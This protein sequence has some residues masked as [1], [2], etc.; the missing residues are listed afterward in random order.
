MPRFW[1]W[2][3]YYKYLFLI[4]ATTISESPDAEWTKSRNLVSPCKQHACQDIKVRLF[5]EL[6]FLSCTACCISSGTCTPCQLYLLCHGVFPPFFTKIKILIKYLYLLTVIHTDTR[7]VSNK[8]HFSS[9]VHERQAPNLPFQLLAKISRTG[10]KHISTWGNGINLSALKAVVNSLTLYK[11]VR[12]WQFR[13]IIKFVD[14]LPFNTSQ[15]IPLFYNRL[16]HIICQIYLCLQA[17][18]F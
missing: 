4:K 6:P 17:C 7:I 13:N 10:H 2:W 3:L 11:L 8:Q 9:W 5:P 16:S 14:V 1:R 18:I 15:A 12:A